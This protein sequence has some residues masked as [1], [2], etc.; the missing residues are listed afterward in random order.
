MRAVAQAEQPLS[1]R[2]VQNFRLRS[3]RS[4]LR[5]LLSKTLLCRTQCASGRASRA[6]LV[7][8]SGAAYSYLILA[9]LALLVVADGDH[10]K[11]SDISLQFT[12]SSNYKNQDPGFWRWIGAAP[13][14]EGVRILRSWFGHLRQYLINIHST[15]L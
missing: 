5:S 1:L 10:F 6:A 12:L 15:F 4:R 14:G 8:V 2:A 7:F 3:Q 13:R 11:I 9:A